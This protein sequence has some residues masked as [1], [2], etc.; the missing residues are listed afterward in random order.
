MEYHELNDDD[1]FLPETIDLYRKLVGDVRYI[2]DST[3]P[4]IAF[5]AGR[6]GA[7][8]AKP[9]ERHWRLMKAALRYLKRTRNYVLFYHKHT[10]QKGVE[11]TCKTRPLCASADSEWGNDK[12]D[13]LS[14]T[15]RFI[16]WKGRRIGWI[17]RKQD[18]V[19][20]MSTAEAEYRAMTDIMQR[21]IYT[22]TLART[23]EDEK[24]YITLENDNLR[25]ITVIKSIGTTKRSKFIDLRYQYLKKMTK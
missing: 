9:T 7:A 4:D 15:G 5:V 11:A 12:V 16:T 24:Q 23:F 21:A 13:R 10:S 17:A 22:Q 20:A 8:S 2:A 14:V 3:R 25:A 19:S 18:A 1:H 6:L